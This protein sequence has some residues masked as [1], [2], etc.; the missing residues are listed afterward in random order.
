MAIDDE[1]LVR[2]VGGTNPFEVTKAVDFTDIEIDKTWVDWPAPGGFATWLD[3]TSPMARIIRGGKGTGRTHVMRHFSAHVQAIRGGDDP[4]AQVIKDGVLGIYVMCSGLDSSR[5]RGTALSNDAWQTVF[6][7]YA[8]L[9][10]AQATLEAFCTVTENSPPSSA[11]ESAITE[12]VRHLMLINDI[13]SGTA[14]IELREGLYR[15]QKEI[16]T[17]VNNAPLYPDRPPKPTI[18]TTLGRLV[19]GIPRAL[20]KHYEPLRDVKFLYLVDE[21]ENFDVPQQQYFNSLVREKEAGTSFMIGVR[22]FGL[23]T[24]Q[25]LGGREDNKHGSEFEE[26]RPERSYIGADKDRYETFCQKVVA[27]RLIEYGFLQKPIV[28]EI[29]E[30]LNAYFELP[31]PEYVEQELI[32]RFQ[33][34]ERPYL[35]RLRRQLLRNLGAAGITHSDVEPIVDATRVASRPLLEKV[36]VFLIYRAW[37]RGSN[38]VVKAREMIDA[39]SSPDLVGVVGSNSAQH[40]ILH[41][42]VTDMKAQLWHDMRL[43]Q[44]YTGIDEFITM[45]DGLPRNLLVILKNVHRWALFNREQP[46]EDSRISIQSQRLGVLAATDWFFDEAKPLGEDGDHVHAAILRL[47]DS[48]RRLRYSDKPVE[49]SLASFS[50]DLTRCSERAREIVE[51][52]AQWALLVRVDKGEKDRNTGFIRSKYHLNRLL[53]PR[54]GLPTARRG[55]IA[56]TAEEVNAIFDPGHAETFS[57]VLNRRL[58]RMNVPFRGTLDE[59]AVQRRLDVD[60][61]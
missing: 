22:T 33:S 50:A 41:H 28:D 58:G 29:E 45:S 44:T 7:Q 47:G 53:S 31:S 43:P 21:F 17:A 13:P 14:L 27:R 1:R 19:F 48:F 34:R 25:T 20:R 60:D 15:I 4:V 37:A 39:R 8:D 40:A 30:R 5:F 35:T 26:I 24:L 49:S 23:R 9:W 42:F 46:F 51:L 57:G 59:G 10:L 16:D 3:I 61:Y 36:N 38:L 18:A 56:L 2:P 55:T 52:A 12:D 54:W 32:R 6:C 11:V